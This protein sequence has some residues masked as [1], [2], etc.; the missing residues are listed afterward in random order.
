[1]ASEI[2]VAIADDHQ[3]IIDGYLYRLGGL[4]QIKVVGTARCGQDLEALLAK[5][6]TDL[7]ILDVGL[8]MSLDKKN[9]PYPILHAIPNLLQRYRDLIILVISMH[10]QRT[11]IDKVMKAGA[12]GYIVK[13]DQ[14]AITKLGSIIELVAN[15]SIYVSPLASE[16]WQAGWKEQTGPS[17]TQRQLEVLSLC[18]AHPELNSRQLAQKLSVEPSTVR[19]LLSDAYKRLKVRNRAAAVDQAREFGLITPRQEA[20]EL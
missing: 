12:K 17:L 13:D 20:Y 2:R 7:L 19:N 4:P 16:E 9:N 10:M 15:G 3:G 5:L 18:A 11:L 8:P 6:A 14:Q 1:M